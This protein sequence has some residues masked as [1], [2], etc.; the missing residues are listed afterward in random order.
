MLRAAAAGEVVAVGFELV[1]GEGL[2][3]PVVGGDVLARGV[4][5]ERRVELDVPALG[6]EGFD[7]VRDGGFDGVA[8][9]DDG[10]AV[11]GGADDV[12]EA[13]FGTGVFEV[14][15]FA[16]GGCGFGDEGLGVVFCWGGRGAR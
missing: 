11:V 13:G 6:L 15:L 4:G 3:L 8:D 2:D 9:F 16:D 14:E 1:V 7:A 12:D 5:G 10:V